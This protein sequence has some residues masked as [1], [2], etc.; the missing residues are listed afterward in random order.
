MAETLVLYGFDAKKE[1]ARLTISPETATRELAANLTFLTHEVLRDDPVSSP[2][3]LYYGHAYPDYLKVFSNAKRTAP[4]D[5]DSQFDP[6]ERGDFARTAFNE[7][8]K[9]AKLHPGAVVLSLSLAGKAGFDNNPDNSFNKITYDT[10]QLYNMFYDINQDKLFAWAVTASNEDL[11]MR[12]LQEFGIEPPARE[13]ADPYLVEL[14]QSG[15]LNT[16]FSDADF[17]QASKVLYYLRKPA[18]TGM[19]IHRYLEFLQLRFGNEV[20]HTNKSDTAFT[21]DQVVHDVNDK[22][23][24]AYEGT[25]RGE[26]VVEKV[27]REIQ[28]GYGAQ[29]AKDTVERAYF[30]T[31]KYYAQAHGINELELAGSCGG[32]SVTVEQLDDLLNSLGA[33]RSLQNPAGVLNPFTSN[34][35]LLQQ[36]ILNV[37]KKSAASLCEK[38]G[39]RHSEKHFHCPEVSQGGCGKPIPSGEGR[40]V[41]P[42][43]RLSKDAYATMTGIKC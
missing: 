35:R 28:N 33:N 27:I 23:S 17:H 2:Y 16:D 43:C 38:T 36:D 1:A 9:Q 10:I 13:Y 34:G 8:A 20:L 37:M 22:L 24:D 15:R 26:A 18:A 14:M 6:R 12:M 30:L 42:H 11:T 19:D 3:E 29:W 5:M 7:S 40:D 4:Y 39:C 31:M 32:T 21:V 41:C 25:V